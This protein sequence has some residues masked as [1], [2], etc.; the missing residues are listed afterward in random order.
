MA[1]AEAALLHQQQLGVVQRLIARGRA[2]HSVREPEAA[3]PSRSVATE[4]ASESASLAVSGRL[5]ASSSKLSSVAFDRR[6]P[7]ASPMRVS[8]DSRPATFRLL[9]DLRCKLTVALREEVANAAH[10]TGINGIREVVEG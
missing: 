1:E 4:R 7:Q 3:G 8:E 9:N 6:A 10:L 5:V 2:P